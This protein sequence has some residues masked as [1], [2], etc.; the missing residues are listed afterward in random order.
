M[1]RHVSLLLFTCFLIALNGCS[2]EPADNTA[3]N[4]VDSG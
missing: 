3:T 4:Q 1:L 2:S